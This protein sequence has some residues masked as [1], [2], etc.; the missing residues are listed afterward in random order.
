VV[1]E[2]E[3]EID[4]GRVCPLGE[5]S[6]ADDG[7]DAQGGERDRAER[8]AQRTIGPLGIGDQLVDGLGGEDLPGQRRTPE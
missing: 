7:P 3:D 5:D 2:A 8:F 4:D 1:Q 6:R